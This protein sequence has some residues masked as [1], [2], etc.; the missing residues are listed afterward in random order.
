M[1]NIFTLHV[2]SSPTCSHVA[3]ARS[4][5]Q[6]QTFCRIPLFSSPQHNALYHRETASQ[7]SKFCLFPFTSYIHSIVLDRALA[8][9]TGFMIVRYIRCEVISP[10]INL[11]LATWY[12][13]QGHLQ[14]PPSG[15]AGETRVRNMAAEFCRRA[16]IV[17]VGFFNMP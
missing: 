7:N 2:V 10:T 9:L 14:T 13:H 4:L 11:V 8:F 16:L 12:D 6:G 3:A 17:L 1:Y 15:G 5:N